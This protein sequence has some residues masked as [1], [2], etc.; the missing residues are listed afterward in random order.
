MCVYTYLHFKPSGTL[1]SW[2]IRGPGRSL[3]DLK[4]VSS[5][6]SH[7]CLLPQRWRQRMKRPLT[8][9]FLPLDRDPVKHIKTEVIVRCGFVWNVHTLILSP[10]PFP[11]MSNLVCDK[12]LRN[13]SFGVADWG[14]TVNAGLHSRS[15][16]YLSKNS[17]IPLATNFY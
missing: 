12:N 8:R 16:Q 9:I 2:A 17:I 10:K 15:C 11:R 1:V 6:N 5:L 13:K 7:C 14:A 3:V 4:T